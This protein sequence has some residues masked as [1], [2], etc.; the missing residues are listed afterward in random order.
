MKLKADTKEKFHV[1]T[2]QE[3]V[4]SADMAAE[5]NDLLLSY[6]QIDGQFTK[7]K[8][9]NII[10]SLKEL[11]FLEKEAAESLVKLQQKFY[12][13]NASFVLCELQKPVED[14]LD[15]L[16]LLEITNNAPTLSEAMDIVQLEELERELLDGE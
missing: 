6:V 9:G 5:L 10:L 3:P 16:N 11:H 4:L 2:V 13:A 1:I 14:F 12:E 15:S 7:N 8:P